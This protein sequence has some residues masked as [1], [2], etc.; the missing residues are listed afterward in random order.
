MHNLLPEFDISALALNFD[1]PNLS[2]CH[3]PLRVS[4]PCRSSVAASQRDCIHANKRTEIRQCSKDIS[5]ISGASDVVR[6]GTLAE[7]LASS[8]EFAWLA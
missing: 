6:D 7:S 2:D 5:I 8:R 1:R 3:H 4:S